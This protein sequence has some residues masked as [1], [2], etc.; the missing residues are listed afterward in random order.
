M[1]SFKTF[2]T[3][4]F[5][6]PI[7]IYLS[8]NVPS[9]WSPSHDRVGYFGAT[10]ETGQIEHSYGYGLQVPVDFDP[11]MV[12]PVSCYLGQCLGRSR[13]I[14]NTPS[15][16]DEAIVR[17]FNHNSFERYIYQNVLYYAREAGFEIPDLYQAVENKELFGL[18]IPTMY[19]KTD[20]DRFV[21]FIIPLGVNVVSKQ[22]VIDHLSKRN[23]TLRDRFSKR[24]Q[25]KK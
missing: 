22:A 6:V 5:N 12:Q 24:R 25:W 10:V 23:N 20:L 17:A 16:P 11:D 1:N 15:I 21:D 3:E 18:M 4:S 2:L 8:Y 19:A 9:S 13:R 7:G 14:L